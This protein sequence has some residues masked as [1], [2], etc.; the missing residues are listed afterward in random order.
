M[1][2][3]AGIWR[4]VPKMVFLRTL[5]E[6]GP[7]ASLRAGGSAGSTWSRPSAGWT[8]STSTGSTSTRSSSAA[9]DGC[10]RPPTPRPTWSWWRTGG[11]ATA[12][13]C[14]ATP[15]DSASSA[16]RDSELAEG[17]PSQFVG[18][19]D[20]VDLGDALVDDRHPDDGDDAAGGPRD[21]PGGTVDQGRPAQRGEAWTM[22]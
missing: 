18:V 8:W 4:S 22:C 10:S 21:D 17:Q 11:S 13:S 9:V 20:Q 3:F 12:S 6:V 2:E 1:R 19:E 7:N 14:C 15:S 5:H 16:Q